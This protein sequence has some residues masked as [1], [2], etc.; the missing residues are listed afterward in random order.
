MKVSV[1]TVCY[2]SAN[3][4]L[5]TINSVN[6]QT[7]LDIEHIFV[8][9]QSKD[10]TLKIIKENSNRNP[11][12]TSEPDSGIYDAMNKGILLCEGEVVFIINSD[13]VL[14]DKFTIKNVVE[15]FERNPKSDIIFG[16]IK[17]SEP[18]NLFKTKRNWNATDFIK[19]SFIKGWHPPHPGFVV[20]KKCYDDFGLFNASYKIASDFNLMYRCLE[21]NKIKATRIDKYIA[22]QRGGGASMKYSGIIQGQKEIRQT[23]KENSIN[24]NMLVYMFN[25]YI[26]KIIQY[27]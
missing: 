2:N 14:Y 6:E 11:T 9:G 22:I 4:I 17:I 18:N 24:L 3:T 5:D 27:K 16:S 25:R 15:A 13:D 1:I 20:K 21:V 7:Y 19:N 8:D 26:S 12:F 10:S 23:F